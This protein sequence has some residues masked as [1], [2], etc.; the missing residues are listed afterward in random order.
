[1]SLG[2]FPSYHHSQ[3][4]VAGT[5][6]NKMKNRE[7]QI[8]AAIAALINSIRW[9][10][11]PD[12]QLLIDAC[13][14]GK[15]GLVLTNYLRSSGWNHEPYMLHLLGYPDWAGFRRFPELDELK[16]IIDFDFDKCSV[17]KPDKGVKLEDLIEAVTV[18]Q[19]RSSLIGLQTLMYLC[20]H[21]DKIPKACLGKFT[22][23]IKSTI[24]DS[25]RKHQ[26]EFVIPAMFV[27]NQAT[28]A[29][30]HWIPADY[31]QNNTGDY[32]T[33]NLT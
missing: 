17:T 19:S 24:R 28:S 22:L 3:C 7:R 12:L 31:R 25:R 21:K 4:G 23:G 14:Q 11:I 16:P 26:N 29:Y 2:R 5:Q 30:I 33:L 32:I 9:D 8:P 1:M 13:N 10:D 20:E 27:D 15:V 18:I 6:I